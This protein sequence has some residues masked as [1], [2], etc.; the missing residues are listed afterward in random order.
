[1]DG[2][3][4]RGWRR[5]V[6]GRTPGLARV[7]TRRAEPRDLRKF[8]ACPLEGSDALLR[9]DRPGAFGSRARLQNP[10][11]GVGESSPQIPPSRLGKHAANIHTGRGVNGG[12]PMEEARLGIKLRWSL[13]WRAAGVPS[14]V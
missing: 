11:G 12:R 2:T 5:L 10:T 3:A 6:V 14:P 1:M 4:G 8:R 13:T 9:R 7:G